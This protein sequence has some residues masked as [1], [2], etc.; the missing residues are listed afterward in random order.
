MITLTQLA[1][2][3]SNGLNE[4]LKELKPN[5]SFKIW[6]EAGEYKPFRRSGNTVTFYINGNLQTT[7]GA[8]EANN[9]IMGINGLSL[10]FAVPIKEPRT[11]AKQTSE[12]LSEIRD[13]QYPFVQDIIEV[14]NR[15]FQKAQ[16]TIMYDGEGK[17]FSI[18]YR[19]GSAVTGAVDLVPELGKVI[20]VSSYIE[21]Y[22]IE[23]GLSSKDVIVYFDNSI[24][25]FTAVRHGR[26]PVVDSDVYSG[27]LVSKN[28]ITSSAIAL[29]I[30]FPLNAD[31]LT[32]AC[33][34]YLLNAEPNVAHFVNAVFGDMGQK[35]FLMTLNVF[36][37]SATGINV[38]GGSV[39]LMEIIEDVDAVNIPVGYQLGRF[40]LANSEEQ[41]LTFTVSDKCN[42]FIAGNASEMQ[43]EQTVNV[44]P[45]NMVSEELTDGTSEYYVYLLTDRNLHISESS[46]PFTIIKEAQNG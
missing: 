36:Q 20:E 37:S 10:S 18:A 26:T 30:D 27:K 32:S 7:N 15:Y 40:K 4:I 8:N 19:A 39:S 46:A 22:F 16:A 11:S 42:A 31:A 43:G 9:L 6:A 21:I 12:E 35:L 29:D 38:S 23:G 5:M 28:L 24:V 34:D 17:K 14:I 2:E 1:D 44:S 13:G 3:F 33:I 41:T 45:Y 25:P